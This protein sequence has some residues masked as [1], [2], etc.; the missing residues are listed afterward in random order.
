MD[1]I[2]VEDSA[3]DLTQI[4]RGEY[5][6]PGPLR[7]QLVSAIL[8]GA[9]TTTACLAEEF[10]RDGE[11]VPSGSRGALEAVVDSAGRVVCLTRETGCEVVRLADVTDE[12][13]IGE[14]EGY[15][16]AAA[17]RA[18]H[19]RFWTSPEYVRAMGEPPV[20]IADDTPVVCFSFEVVE[21]YA[22]AIAP[23]PD[24][25]V[26]PDPSVGPDPSAGPDR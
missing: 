18:G 4:P 17:W 12:H 6:F 21:Q 25:S 22:D 15:A 26:E 10:T 20:R 3:Y 24:P 8:T 9:K 5:A 23:S 13:A 14:G 1:P 7:D 11:P 2:R 19:E 16:D